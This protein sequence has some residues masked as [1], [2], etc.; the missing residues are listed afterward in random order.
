MTKDSPLCRA[1][2]RARLRVKLKDK[3]KDNLKGKGE[4]RGGMGDGIAGAEDSTKAAGIS[5]R[6][7]IIS[8]SGVRGSKRF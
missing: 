6:N 1:K 5:R 2:L 3:C 8:I 4:A 7:S